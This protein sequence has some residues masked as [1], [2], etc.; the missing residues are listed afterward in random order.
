MLETFVPEAYFQPPSNVAMKYPCIVYELDD[1]DKSYANNIVY[2]HLKK[3]QVKLIS[4][5]P[6][7]PI[8]D[9]LDMLPLCSFERR[10]VA[11]NLTHDVFNLFF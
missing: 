5:D 4:N 7:D 1:D 3:Y 6:D 10:Y 9:L 8:R 11:A 2:R